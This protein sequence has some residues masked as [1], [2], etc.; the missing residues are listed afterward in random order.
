MRSSLALVLLALASSA[1]D[2]FPARVVHQRV[3]LTIAPPAGGQG[4]IRQL[5]G[6]DQVPLSGSRVDGDKGDFML[7]SGPMVA[8]VS[9]E[10][11]EIVD[12][13]PEGAID[14]VVAITAAVFDPL[15]QARS[16]VVFIGVEPEAP[17]VLHIVRRPPSVPARLHTF[18]TFRGETLVMESTIEPESIKDSGM[19][20]GLGERIG[21][22]NHPT[23]VQ[24][25]GLARKDA[26]QETA[27]F[28]GRESRGLSYAIGHEG[29]ETMVRISSVGL[30]GFFAVGRAS[31]LSVAAAGDRSPRRTV[32][33]AASESSIG[34]AASKLYAPSSMRTHEGV[35]SPVRG[36]R[37]EVAE[38]PDEEKD[39]PR[40]PYARFRPGEPLVFP[41][42]G[43]F[44]ARLWAPGHK[45]TEWTKLEEL[46]G[47]ALAPSGSL[48]V[49][50]VEGGKAT[51]ARVQ[52]RGVD[53]TA[54]PDWGEDPEDG[55]AVNTAHVK[56]GVLNRPVPPGRYKVVADRGFEYDAPEA[57][58]EVRS[59]HNAYVALEL[60]R[61]VDTAGWISADLHLHADPSPDAPQSL[62]DRVLALAAAGVEVGVATDHNRVSDYRPAISA[63]GLGSRVASVIGDEV[64]TEE[65]AFGHFNVFPLASGSE[66][67]R[68][69]RTSPAAIFA[70]ARKRA[71]YGPSTIIQVNHPRMGDIGYLDVVRFDR[72]DVGAFVAR[73]PWAPLDFDAMEV[74]NGDDATSPSVVRGVM[75]DWFALMDSG[76]RLTATGN[77]DAHR[78]T[79]HEPGLP[80]T[81]VEMANDDP[82]RF[83]ERA[84]VTAL[85]EGRAVVSS[86]P[87]IRFKV[88]AAGIG[89]TVPPGEHEA[90]VVVYAP[91]W[92]HISYVELWK[93]GKLYKRVEG[94]FPE[95]DH[96]ATLVESVPV[97]SGDWLIAVAG[98]TKEM[99]PLYRRG[100]PPFAF[101]NAIFVGP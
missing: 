56:A 30:A 2:L 39:K 23:W 40:R 34:H 71:P 16:P 57:T 67:L 55:S 89:G 17:S 80:R 83:D 41:A 27:A 48:I 31:E 36:A 46:N 93:S 60:K 43:C 4:T 100:V 62:E 76:R 15:S 45:S 74:F 44:E 7:Q 61:A 35:S 1:C 90:K 96:A 59:G 54:S 19:V 24:G 92:V 64:T 10:Y 29:E 49:S 81:Y 51:V 95:G 37:V 26:V 11:G 77:S 14:G 3:G 84:F 21:W 101:T 97:K 98:G 22:G 70:E 72:D 52:V 66:P 13:G 86:G 25:V 9:R 53:G 75:K 18:V 85:R 68:Y 65:M 88:G 6:R 38:C 5:E 12:F 63:L 33:L 73:T 50:I 42:S 20:V 87:F 32:L 91:S 47:L 8:V 99:A 28:V 79:F 69:Q 94:P 58:I 78:L 82:A